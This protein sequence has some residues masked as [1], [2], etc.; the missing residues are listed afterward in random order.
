VADRDD[1]ADAPDYV[2]YE[3]W[4][5][6]F[7]GGV[8]TEERILGAV[9]NLAGQPINVG[10]IGV[11][12]GKIAQVR[13]RGAIGRA[14]SSPVS[15]DIVSYR[16]V[17][18]VELTFEVDLQLD[19][20][21]FHA[22]L[23][24]PLVLAARAASP[25]K[26]V[27]DIV[28]PLPDEVTIKLKSAGLRASLLNRVVGIEGEL[29]RFVATYVAREVQKPTIAKLRVIDVAAAIDGAMKN[30]GLPGDRATPRAVAADFEEAIVEEIRENEDNL[31]EG[32]SE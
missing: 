20:H 21:R 10:P 30:I 14:Q 3:Q 7:F 6:A 16:V 1:N 13:A 31:I 22:Q 19:R 29:Q 4:G 8:V 5:V 11:G 9:N 12:P 23:E 32:I 18:P 24:V 26:I 28:P 2:S 27:I 17:L 25:L 15:G